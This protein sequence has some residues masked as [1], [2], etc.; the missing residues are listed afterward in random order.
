MK[1]PG[2][3]EYFIRDAEGQTVMRSIHTNGLYEDFYQ[4]AGGEGVLK[5]PVEG[6]RM[7]YTLEASFSPFQY[8]D[9]NFDPELIQGAFG[10]YP[11][12][13]GQELKREFV[14]ENVSGDIRV[15]VEE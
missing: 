8:Q 6:K 15:R 12:G 5:A 13:R 1:V 11:L 4:Y 7:L 9:T 14:I 3:C 10:G 2:V